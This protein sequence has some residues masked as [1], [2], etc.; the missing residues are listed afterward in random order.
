MISLERK[1]K[2]TILRQIE[3]LG[4]ITI[5]NAIE[6]VTPHFSF[7]ADK[8][9]KSAI[10]RKAISLIAQSRDEK[11]VRKCFV[12]KDTKGISKAINVEKSNCLAELLLVESAF[13]KVMSGYY[14]SMAKV[15][16]RKSILESQTSI[17]DK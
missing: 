3:D 9:R 12:I 8:S 14:G 13:T 5:E 4:E 15:K 6:L 2:E 1:A 17:F 10:R 7:D 11:G 16:N